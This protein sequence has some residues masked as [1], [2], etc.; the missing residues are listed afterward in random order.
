MTDDVE[1]ARALVLGWLGDE[2]RFSRVTY[3]PTPK[4]LNALVS[5]IAAELSAA[6]VK[7]KAEAKAEKPNLV[8]EAFA[9]STR[10]TRSKR[11][12]AYKR[13]G[14]ERLPRNPVSETS[15]RWLTRRTD[16]PLHN[17]CLS[18]AVSEN[19]PQWSCHRCSGPA[20]EEARS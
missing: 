3:A 19:W 5:R 6:I 20:T 11:R 8:L 10:R 2:Y 9:A 16:C 1:T 12:R 15:P 7:A 18:K 14:L 13:M 17:A 4:A